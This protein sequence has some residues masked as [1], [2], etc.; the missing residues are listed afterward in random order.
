M[1]PFSIFSDFNSRR[2]HQKNSYDR[3]D[4]ESVDEKVYL[5]L[6]PEKRWK[7]NSGWKGLTHAPTL[8]LVKHERYGKTLVVWVNM[9]AM[10]KLS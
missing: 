9:N 3:R 6:C 8:V 5:R 7:K 10:V 2:G 1:V 4:Y